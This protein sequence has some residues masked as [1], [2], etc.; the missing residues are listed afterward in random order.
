MSEAVPFQQS[1]QSIGDAPRKPGL[2]KLMRLAWQ[3]RGVD[4]VVHLTERLA[5]REIDA[6]FYSER[7]FRD[8]YLGDEA[9]LECTRRYD[10]YRDLAHLLESTVGLRYEHS[11]E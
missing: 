5:A 7:G 3:L 1:G 10:G 11:G 6:A 8:F 2:M 4:T 9:V